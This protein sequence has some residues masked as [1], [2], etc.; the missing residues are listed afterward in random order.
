L[1]EEERIKRLGYDKKREAEEAKERERLEAEQRKKAGEIS[2]NGSPAGGYGARSSAASSVKEVKAPVRL[3]FGATVGAPAPVA[4]S[5]KAKEYSGGNES[6]YA[7]DKFGTQKGISSDQYFGRGSYDPAAAAE[8]QQRSAQFGG[9]TA[10]S[11]NAYFGRPEDDDEDH[12]GDEGLL[13]DNE[14]LAG[15]ERGIRDLAGKV[16]ANPEV[17]ALGENIRTGALKLSDYLQQMSE[18]R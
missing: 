9:A 15:L 2:R 13:G 10:I 16:M 17:Q 1:E 11:S 12:G 18:H 3:G 6:T 14:S 7:R 8:A 5:S 4:T